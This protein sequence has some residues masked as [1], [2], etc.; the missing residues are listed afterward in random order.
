MSDCCP[1]VLSGA[2][3]LCVTVILQ[4]SMHSTFAHSAGGVVIGPQGKVLVVQQP[5]LSWSL[6][7]GH[8]A[9]GEEP[10]QT[11]M[12]EIVE[13]SGLSD[14]QIMKILK[15]YSRYK[16][17]A[18]GTDDISSIK[19]ITMYLCTTAQK[20]LRPIDTKILQAVWM[21]PEEVAD[22]LTHPKDQEFFRE[23]LPEVMV[24]IK[25]MGREIL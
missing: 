5:D 2:P 21:N 13:E 17:S 25:G 22:M 6:P 10:Q 23:V 7:K 18:S 14:V 11:A 8:I 9:N 24:C 19:R 4:T 12:R 1:E 3:S 15:S 16:L 20:E